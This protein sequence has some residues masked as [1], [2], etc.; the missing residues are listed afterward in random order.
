M[1]KFKIGKKRYRLD[2]VQ[3]ILVMLT[4]VILTCSLYLTVNLIKFPS[5]YLTITRTNLVR[6]VKD[7]N[8]ESIEYYEKMYATQG[9]ELF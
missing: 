4:F 6:D 3:F 7:G 2:V 5:K 8:E 1:L 9:V